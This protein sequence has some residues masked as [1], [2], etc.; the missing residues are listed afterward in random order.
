MDKFAATGLTP[1]R[2]D[3]VDA[4]YVGE[5]S[6]ALECVLRHT[7]K[8]GSNT[9][10]VGEVLGIQASEDVLDGDENL[11]IRLVRPVL[12]APSDRTYIGVGE[13]LDKP[14]SIGRMLVLSPQR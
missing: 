7:S 12:I 8:T 3:L 5:F 4:P 11:D 9:R 14:F 1:V 6:L 2:S 13:F 10:F